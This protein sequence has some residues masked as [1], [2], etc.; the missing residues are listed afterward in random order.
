MLLA[1][2]KKYGH[3][4]K[5]ILNK[6]RKSKQQPAYGT[7]GTNFSVLSTQTNNKLHRAKNIHNS[8]STSS[9]STTKRPTKRPQ[10]AG[11]RRTPNTFTNYSTTNTNNSTYPATKTT[12]SL[13][14]SGSTSSFN[15][16][17]RLTPQQILAS[18]LRKELRAVHQILAHVPSPRRRVVKAGARAVAAA[19]QHSSLTFGR[20]TLDIYANVGLVE[21]QTTTERLCTKL[22]KAMTHETNVMTLQHLRD[23]GAKELVRRCKE[24]NKNIGNNNNNNTTNTNTT[25]TTDIKENH[26]HRHRRL[27]LCNFLHPKKKK[28]TREKLKW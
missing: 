22:Q 12:S 7:N 28:V 11:K 1:N 17:Q 27:S 5:L 15:Q 23:E 25:N 6:R 3:T 18:S 24:L 9:Y 26:H 14:T 2:A 21:A 4:S 19:S 20:N 8:S 13:T 10:S 16:H